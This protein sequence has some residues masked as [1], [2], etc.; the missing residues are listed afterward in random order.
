MKN[1]NWKKV[2]PHAVAILIFL[3][4]AV[5]YCKPVLEGKVLQQIDIVNW[6]GGAQDAFDY[7]AK[8][9]HFPLWN[10]HMFSGMPNYQIAMEG[11][12]LLPNIT[13]ILT[14]GL[15]K[16]IAF[17]FL[18]CV[19]FYI[20]CMALRINV[21]V[22]IMGALAFAYCTYNPVIVAVGH[23]S[24]MW[25]IA[26]MPAL[27]AGLLLLYDKKYILGFLLTALFATME[28][29]VNHPQIN[30]YFGIIAVFITIFYAI[31][32]IKNKEFKH[33][34]I[35]AC[36]ALVA[37]GVGLANASISL[38]TTAEYT[39]YTIRGGKLIDTSPTG[40]VVKAKTQGLDPSYGFQYSAAKSEFLTF[41]MPDVKG[42]SLGG[43]YGDEYF[44]E[45]SKIVTA[46]A[47]K[48]VPEATGASV[49]QQ[50]P[51]YWG[52]IMPSTAGPVYIGAI[53]CILF[54]IG[55]VVV[56][57]KYKW[58]IL[59]ACA[60][61]IIISWG[62]YFEGF[63]TFLFDH[64]PMY[65]KFRAPSMAM[66]IPQLLFPLMAVLT[67]Q[68]LFY[69]NFSKA[70][71]KKAFKPILYV[72]G[73]VF[74]V[75]LLMYAAGDFSNSD[76]DTNLKTFG[77][78]KLNGNGAT[79]LGAVQEER[80]AM[81]IN[82]ILQALG[83]A[84]LTLG[85][86]YAW[87]KTN[88]KPVYLVLVLLVINSLNLLVVDNKYLSDNSYVDKDSY[89]NDN[90]TPNAAEAEILKD[91]DPHYRVFNLANDRYSEGLTA[92][93]VRA[94]GGYH[95]AKLS[96]YQDLYE[97]QIDKNNEK[98]LDMLDTR[99][100]IV[101]P[102]QQG[103]PYQ[104]VKRDSA[105]GAAWF[106]K[107]VKFVDGPVAEM[108]SL[109]KFDPKQTAFVDNSFKSS[110]AQQPVADSSASIKLASYDNDDIKYTTSSKTNQFAVL[111]EI[112]YP[113]GWEAT[114]DGNTTP[115]VR[116]NYA[117]RGI[118]VPA[119]NHTV[120]FKFKP[121]SY[122]NGQLYVYIGNAIIWLAFLVFL[123]SVYNKNRKEK[124]L[125]KA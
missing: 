57:A 9:G 31:Q 10:T 125:A 98:V 49:A 63:N 75:L 92:Y 16:P 79:L 70:D 112:Y 47:N 59:S 67:L 48:G 7:K 118:Y 3:L 19:C 121:K 35:T 38:L 37:V 64:F 13:A 87:L 6:K 29:G 5:I 120:E 18:A 56:D 58:W 122:Y 40:E 46:L 62:K 74:V 42:S 83:F 21:V 32:W 65:N 86:L 66:V 8:N 106:V 114:I 26:Y 95:P 76:L 73:G 108:K 99:Y 80:K 111:S 60:F 52:G 103:Q 82:G 50:I 77:D 104:A 25:A 72:V 54:L 88:I 123:W 51:R 4:V 124:A 28:I 107:E 117:L 69:N 53:I 43:G 116:T 1:F 85:V 15:P 91:K 36:L 20:L 24:K 41:M 101:P 23:E 89:S 44:D 55:L 94:V 27:L 109:D 110:I 115:Y 97:N 71:L 100:F 33:I 90:F 22:G 61:G 84:L 102:R 11:H 78:E 96:I 34:L 119:G 81:L 12:S 113:A 14:L 30:F 45:N 68:K 2:L 93:F 105:M 17:F 39:Q